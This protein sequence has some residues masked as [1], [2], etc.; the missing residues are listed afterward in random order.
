[1]VELM[2]KRRYRWLGGLGLSAL[3]A[4]PI[5]MLIAL[6]D[7]AASGAANSFFVAAASIGGLLAAGGV[8]AY[9]E[10]GRLRRRW[11]PNLDAASRAGKPSGE[12][13]ILTRE[14][15]EQLAADAAAN[16]TQP[17]P[18]IAWPTGP[19]ALATD[20]AIRET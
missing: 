2:R 4:A 10:R 15:H 20:G 8:G 14:Y 7:L 1:M 18:P 17:P 11:D 6:G 3:I 19:R 16:G 12:V 5:A 9:V 13:H